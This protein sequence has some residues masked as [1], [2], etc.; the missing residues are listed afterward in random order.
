M[1]LK[2]TLTLRP[3]SLSQPQFP[4][5]EWN[6]ENRRKS[7][8]A[9]A[10]WRR[11]PPTAASGF[12]HQQ[13]QKRPCTAAGGAY[14]GKQSRRGA[15]YGQRRAFFGRSRSANFGRRPG[16]GRLTPAAAGLRAFT[17]EGR[18]WPVAVN[19]RPI[20]PP[21]YPARAE[22][23]PDS[24]GRWGQDGYRGTTLACPGRVSRRKGPGRP[25][26]SGAGPLR[27]L[28]G[29]L[30]TCVHRWTVGRSAFP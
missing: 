29:E 13:G 27:G 14:Q 30:H 3:G 26:G 24:G 2:Q 22:S 4:Y 9:G 8:P 1:V 10:L 19:V 18:F 12:R 7:S 6:Y 28:F 17:S 11:K 25:S 23:A 15:M 16:S 21:G 20:S 5:L